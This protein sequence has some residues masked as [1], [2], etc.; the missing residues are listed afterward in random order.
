VLENGVPQALTF[1][2][3]TDVPLALALLLD[4][5]ASMEQALATAQ[6]AVIGFVRQLERSDVASVINFD[7]GVQVLH[8]FTAD[9]ASLEQ[10]I[11]LTKAGGSTAL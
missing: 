6:E 10:A 8:D 5:S 11:R 2:G 3:K 4:T 7:S 9:R 1:F